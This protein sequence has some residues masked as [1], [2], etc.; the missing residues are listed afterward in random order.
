MIVTASSSHALPVNPHTLAQRIERRLRAHRRGGKPEPVLLVSA[1]P[2][3][4]YDPILPVNDTLRVRVVPCI[5]TLAIWEQLAESHELPTAILTDLPEEELGIG[6]LSRVHRRRIV[7]MDPWTL[8]T[9]AFGAQQLDPRLKELSWAGR[10]LVEATPPGGWPR[11]PGIVLQRDTALRHLAV[12]RLQLAQLGTASEDVDP[13]SLLRWSAAPVAPQSLATLSEAERTGLLDWLTSE[14]GPAVRVMAALHEVGHVTDT[15]PLG[16]VCEA[17]WAADD[18][19]SLRAQG[20][21]DQYLGGIHLDPDTIASFA[22]TANRTMVGLLTTALGREN[23]R[24]AARDS[25]FQR[26]GGEADPRQL[27]HSVLDRAEELLLGFAATGAAHH[28]DI[29]R[30][31]FTHRLGEAAQALNLAAKGGATPE[32]LTAAGQAIDHLA[33]HHLAA[34]YPHRVQRAEMALRLARWLAEPAPAPLGVAEGVGRQIEQWSW[35]DLALDHVWTGEDAHAGLAA[36]YKLIHDQALR[37]R[38][39]LDRAFAVHLATWTGSGG[40]PGDLL[41]VE[42]VLPRVVAPLVQEG[43][44]PVL[45]VVIDGMTAAIAADLGDQL[46]K[47]G[48]L[49]YDP[50]AS[51]PGRKTDA[52]RR[53]VVAALPTVTTVSRASLLAGA[54]RTGGQSEERSA[55]EGNPLWQGRPAKLF[56]KSTLQGEA[57]E[58]LSDKVIRALSD[59]RTVVGVVVNTVDDGLRYGRESADAGWR[60]DNLGVLRALLDYARYQGRAVILTSDHGHIPEREGVL[61]SV[62]E[63]VSAR[64]RTDPAPAT[65][66]E[67]E[68]A[69][70]R[71]VTDGGRVI[72]LWDPQARYLPRQAGYHGGAS[73]AEVTVPLLALLPLGAAAPSGWR[74]LGP[75]HPHW[76]STTVEEAA[77]SAGVSTQPAKPAPVRRSDAKRSSPATTGTPLFEL[78]TEAPTALAAPAAQTSA[79]EPDGLVNALIASEI[80]EA[81]HSLT[82][83]KMAISKIRGALTALVDANGILPTVLVAEKAGE[84]PARATGFVTTLQRIFNVDNFPI[85]SLIDDGRTVRLDM[86]LLR[87]QFQLPGGRS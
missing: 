48:W 26:G 63:P 49:E 50:L 10:A 67:V 18:P 55:F 62:V 85:L 36:A 75:Q 25:G 77:G 13:S 5:S 39:E 8:I 35:V 31:S 64:H 15:L 79:D 57:G 43:N 21:V 17:L 78:P 65:D 37:R 42:T 69:G 2:V 4:P 23:I 24:A 60:I 58:V 22:A 1:A 41:T 44:R 30:S 73:L 33:N 27:A 70:P 46:A 86:A 32:T 45:V 81:Q 19:D 71:V 29:L 40:K 47:Q 7:S 87:E 28:S 76:W 84:Q 20:R 16:L 53:G 52:R 66:G 6:I 83:R 72:A 82:P 74:L 61:R 34:H 51:R 56:H 11:L 3:W 54:L 14:F 68:L 59:P 80:F 38:R 9:E 12:E